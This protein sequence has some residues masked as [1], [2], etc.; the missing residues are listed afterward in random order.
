M[1]CVAAWL[2]IA[3]DEVERTPCREHLALSIYNPQ[4]EYSIAVYIKQKDFYR[5]SGRRTQVAIVPPKE[6]YQ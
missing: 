6:A 2:V 5:E 3:D 4:R 1:V